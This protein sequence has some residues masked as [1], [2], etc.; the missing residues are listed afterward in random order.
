MYKL[1]DASCFPPCPV[2]LVGIL[3]APHGGARRTRDSRAEAAAL[4]E[5]LRQE[6]GGATASPTG[7]PIWR[8]VA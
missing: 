3:C 4:R 8:E 6:A 2:Q 1:R 5:E 7:S